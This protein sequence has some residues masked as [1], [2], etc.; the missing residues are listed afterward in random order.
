LTLGTGAGVRLTIFFRS[1]AALS[2]F[3]DALSD[4]SDALSDLSEVTVL[5]QPVLEELVEFSTTGVVVPLVLGADASLGAEEVEVAVP[6]VATASASFWAA[7]AAAAD[8]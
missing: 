5:S 2:D 7:V 6:F 4:L 8:A 1:S 3:S